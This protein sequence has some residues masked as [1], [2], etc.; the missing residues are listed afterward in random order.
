M[1]P[2]DNSGRAAIALDRSPRSPARTRAAAPSDQCLA[3]RRWHSRHRRSS[4]WRSRAA[5]ARP[6][7]IPFH[8][9]TRPPRTTVDRQDRERTPTA[10]RTRRPVLRANDP[11]AMTIAC[12]AT[13]IRHRPKWPSDRDAAGGPRRAPEAA[14]RLPRR[15]RFGAVVRTADE[16][17]STST[18]APK[19]PMQRGYAS[20]G[21]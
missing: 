4:R 6:P 1:L 8:R 2:C 18:R 16:G 5:A 14:A 19:S 17:R 12:D 21:H 9:A 11:A 13:A 10:R 15:A 3:Y 7:A 20:N